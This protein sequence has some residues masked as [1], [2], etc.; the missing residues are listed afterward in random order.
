LWLVL[1]N[2]GGVGQADN[3]GVRL[4]AA[5]AGEPETWWDGIPFQRIL[6]DAPCTATG[7]IRRHPE[8]KWLRTFEQLQRAAATQARLLRRL[9]PLLETSGIL[10]YA[11]CSVLQLENNKQIQQFI[12]QHADAEPIAIDADWGREQEFGRQILPG[13]HDMDGFFYARLRKKP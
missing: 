8:I 9:W 7:V 11:T 4:L 1:N 13:E 10:L 3:S 5:D 2:R 6:L 12:E